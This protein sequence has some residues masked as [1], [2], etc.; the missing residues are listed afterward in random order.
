MFV[1]CVC[2]IHFLRSI[3]EHKYSSA[4]NIGEKQGDS[5]RE[6]P[7]RVGII[8][9]SRLSWEQCSIFH[10]ELELEFY[11]NQRLYFN[12]YYYWREGDE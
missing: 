6:N 4:N 12:N 2:S 11:W 10:F 1:Y 9:D 5:K 7:L 8:E 3:L